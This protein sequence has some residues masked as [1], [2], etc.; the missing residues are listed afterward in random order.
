MA[1]DVSAERGVDIV[2]SAYGLPLSD[3]TAD[4]V[5]SGQMLEHCEFFWKAFREMVRVLNKDGFLFLIAP[6]A[7]PIHRHPVDCCRFHPDGFKALAEYAGCRLVRVWS[8]ERG[9][10]ND[11]IGV[12]SKSSIYASV[13][14]LYRKPDSRVPIS[15]IRRG[16]PE[17][18]KIGGEKKSH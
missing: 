11:V 18:E 10:W 17:E 3:N 5:L 13:D 14:S 2:A 16:T 1:S 9:P 12:F 15:E 8:D 4:I 6:S 7:G